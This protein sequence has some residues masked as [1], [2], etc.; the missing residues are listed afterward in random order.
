MRVA[1]I[2]DYD[3]GIE[4]EDWPE[5][6]PT[7]DEVVVTV[8][9]AG[10]CHTDIHLMQRWRNR[11]LPLVLG[12]E[13][14]GIE[15]D[16]GT[17]LVHQS[18][19]CGKCAAC[20]RG[21]EQLCIA[22]REAGF[23]RPGGFAEKIVVPHRRYLIPLG[24]LDPVRAAPLTDA[25]AT[26]YRAIRRAL[27]W[28]QRPKCRAMVFGVGGVGQFAIQFLRLMTDATVVAVDVSEE[29]LKTALDLGAHEACHPDDL[30]GLEAQAVFDLVAEGDTLERAARLV[31][32]G[33]LIMRIGSGGATLVFGRGVL[34]PEVMLTS[35]LGGSMRDVTDVVAMAREGKLRWEVETMPLERVHE[36]LERLERG[37]VRGRLILTPHLRG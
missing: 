36:G 37:E 28:L 8:H 27:P 32:S 5:P 4:L 21:E 33:G 25:G 22:I 31:P 11:P 7:G 6:A 30:A 19:G 29:K 1:V 20:Q 12:H 9:G 26:S 18:W 34:R 23:E 3:K 24:D 10:I 17:V 13:V 2:R 35:S 15:P 16:M 14:A